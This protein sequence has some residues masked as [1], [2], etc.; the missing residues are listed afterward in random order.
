MVGIFLIQLEQRFYPIQKGIT[1]NDVALADRLSTAWVTWRLAG[2]LPS[3]F[4]PRALD[5]GRLAC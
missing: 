2:R 1:A 4:G 3:F 5:K